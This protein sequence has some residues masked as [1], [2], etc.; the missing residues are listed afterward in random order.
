[1][2]LGETEE[3]FENPANPYT[4]A[5]L[6]AIPEPDPESEKRR[7]TLRGTPPSPRDPPSGCP[8]ST[9]CPVK[10]RPAEYEALDEEVWARIEV[11]QEVLRE[12]EHADRSLSERARELLGIE[13]RFSNVG[14]I[15]EEVFADVSVPREVNEHL[16]RAE[17]LVRDRDERAA[18]EHLQT[19]FGGE[20]ELERPEQY[21]VSEAER[22]S[23]CHRHK[24]EH[25]SPDVAFEADVHGGRS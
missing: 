16:I 10:I 5:L 7:I 17:E 8:F 1:M 13:T 3:L 9:R 2:E 20:C 19:Q 12:R 22:T 25:R 4:Q 11:F 18:R 24:S 14:E 23:L 21:E 15:R 6:S